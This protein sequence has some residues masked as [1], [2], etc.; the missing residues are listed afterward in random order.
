MGIIRSSRAVQWTR[1]RIDSLST[2]E[3]RQ[4]RANAER[5]HEP[6]VT[7]LCD[8]VLDARPRG[9]GPRSVKAPKQNSRPKKATAP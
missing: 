1:E 3:V 5:L 6:E 7:A 4:L 8:E 9:G 2:I